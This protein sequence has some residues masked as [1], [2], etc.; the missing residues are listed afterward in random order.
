MTRISPARVPLHFYLLCKFDTF[1]FYCSVTFQY[2]HKYEA[3]S[4]PQ[5]KVRSLRA[6]SSE[7]STLN[8]AYTADVTVFRSLGERTIG[9][10]SVLPRK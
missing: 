1:E 9:N 6:I 4:M 2:S 10:S 3:N 8:V 7:R 5:S